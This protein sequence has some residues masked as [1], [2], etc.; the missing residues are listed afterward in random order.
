[1]TAAAHDL[2]VPPALCCPVC[3]HYAAATAPGG[4]TREFAG[5]AESAHLARDFVRAALAARCNSCHPGRLTLSGLPTG[6]PAPST[7]TA[8]LCVTELVANAIAYTRSGLPGGIVAVTVRATGDGWLVQVRD[9]GAV[10]VPHLEA[11]PAG[12]AEHGHGLR[13]VDVLADEWGSDGGPDGRT[14]W[15]LVGG[16]W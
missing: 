4:V 13:L 14:V 1:V 5:V 15:F 16:D 8:D 7:D 2:S 11:E 12:L 3:I 9:D 6:R 10:S